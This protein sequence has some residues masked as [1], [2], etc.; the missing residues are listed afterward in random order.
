[1][2]IIEIEPLENGAH[3]NQEL[4]GT[5]LAPEDLPEGWAVVPEE[6]EV[7]ESYPF[8]NIEAEN[9][10]VT[11]MTA[12]DVPAPEQKPTPA[13][14]AQDRLEAQVVYTAMMTDTLLEK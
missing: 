12:G 4:F 7:P 2:K 6:M 11:A 8:V 5:A 9:G 1:M 3:R 13:P 10:T 14:T